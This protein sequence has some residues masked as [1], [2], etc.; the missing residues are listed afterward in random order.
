MK[1][2]N[3]DENEKLNWWDKQNGGS[4]MGNLRQNDKG[5]GIGDGM[6]TGKRN[7]VGNGHKT[8]GK[9]QG[10][11]SETFFGQPRDR[12]AVE[13]VIPMEMCRIYALMPSNA[14]LYVTVEVMLETRQCPSS[15]RY[16][17]VMLPESPATITPRWLGDCLL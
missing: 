14:E 2:E 1:K 10:I 4:E 6:G 11:E 3:K 12:T 17:I 13:I 5:D 9:C 16:S 15:S 7:G 8:A